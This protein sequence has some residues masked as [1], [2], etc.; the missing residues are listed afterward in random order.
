MRLICT[1]C[2]AWHSSILKCFE[3]LPKA[4]GSAYMCVLCIHREINYSSLVYK[5]VVKDVLFL[6]YHE[7]RYQIGNS[8]YYSHAT[9]I[10]MKGHRAALLANK[11]KN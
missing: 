6:L 8:K 1:V 10:C 7:G 3:P 2:D 5:N 9:S 4:E 11:K